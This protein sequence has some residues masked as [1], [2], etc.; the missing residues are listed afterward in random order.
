MNFERDFYK[1]CEYWTNWSTDILIHQGI[2]QKSWK[3][4]F[5]KELG[6]ILVADCLASATRV[7]QHIWDLWDALEPLL[8]SK[9][10]SPE[11]PVILRYLNKAWK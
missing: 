6:K 4:D 3:N 8:R 1:L 7:F 11:A 5:L 2:N 9:G 10:V